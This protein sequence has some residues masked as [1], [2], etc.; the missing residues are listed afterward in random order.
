MEQ[1]VFNTQATAPSGATLT[2][3]TMGGSTINEYVG[4]TAAD[5]LPGS[6]VFA[7]GTALSG[8]GFDAVLLVGAGQNDAVNTLSPLGKVENFYT[9]PEAIGFFKGAQ[10]LTVPVE[11]NDNVTVAFASWAV[12]STGVAGAATS[13]A[14]AQA[15][16]AAGYAGYYWG[17][18]TTANLVA[19]TGIEFNPFM[20]ATIEG[21]S[22]GTE[23]VPEPGTI[24]LGVMGASALLFRHRK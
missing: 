7:D 16:E 20:P 8:T 6:A 1:Q 13:L 22:L 19:A 2:T 9:E 15:Y 17:V 4:S 12:N 11:A 23:V 5:H 14:E 10:G 3:V 24:A 21:F 18:S